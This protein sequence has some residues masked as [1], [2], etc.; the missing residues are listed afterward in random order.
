MGTLKTRSMKLVLLLALALPLQSFAA[1][2]CGSLDSASPGAH[3]HCVDPPNGH[4]SGDAQQ[5]HHC[6]SC[7][8]AAVATA[9]L[10][11]APPPPINS[12]IFLPA[13]SALLKIALDRLDRPPRL[14]NR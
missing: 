3:P 12:G 1:I 10:R 7:C 6:G 5:H 8:T 14:A 9:P 2:G 11:W 13:R 4:P